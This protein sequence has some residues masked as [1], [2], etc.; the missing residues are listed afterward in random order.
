MSAW[1]GRIAVAKPTIHPLRR[2]TLKVIG[3]ASFRTVDVVADGNGLSSREG[4]PIGEP[5]LMRG[6]VGVSCSLSL[7]T[8]WA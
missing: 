6:L 3:S 5:G 4:V 7:R 1:A 8:R 2:F